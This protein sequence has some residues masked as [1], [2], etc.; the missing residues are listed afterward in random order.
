MIRGISRNV[1]QNLYS[2]RK[3]ERL[4][5]SVYIGWGDRYLGY[6]GFGMSCVTIDVREGRLDFYQSQ[7]S[8]SDM[9][10]ELLNSCCLD[11]PCAFEIFGTQ[12]DL[13]VP[14]LRF[15][16]LSID[17]CIVSDLNT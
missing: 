6:R 8:G 1:V 3:S 7:S 15:P 10:A 14:P 9:S 17:S 4:V 2:M 11:L 13:E 12:E 5:Q 16:S